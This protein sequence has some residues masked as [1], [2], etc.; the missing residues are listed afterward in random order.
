[1]ETQKQLVRAPGTYNP[2]VKRAVRQM[3]QDE[4][5]YLMEMEYNPIT[6]EQRKE[7]IDNMVSKVWDAD[8]VSNKFGLHKKTV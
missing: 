7:I 4:Y 1:M 8:I 2:I 5:K 6:K 3:P